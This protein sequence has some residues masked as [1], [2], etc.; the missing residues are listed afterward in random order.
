[1]PKLH[2]LKKKFLL[3]TILLEAPNFFIDHIK[4]F[5]DDEKIF[6]PN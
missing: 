1:M 2:V 3:S 4:M 6:A 5:F